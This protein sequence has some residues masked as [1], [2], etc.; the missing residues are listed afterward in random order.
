MSPSPTDAE[1]AARAA[2]GDDRAYADLVGRHKDGLYRLLRR[3]AGDPE[4]AHEAVQEAFIAAW[5]ALRRYDPARP[6]AAWLRTIAINKARD[7]ARRA[8]VR[9]LVFGA[10]RFEDSG[11]MEH[12][13]AE[14]PADDQVI[15]RQ[16]V[17]ALD[18]AIAA[19]P[20]A[21]KA[22]LILTALEGCS[23][24]EAAEILGVSAKA[25]ET[26]TYRARRLLMAT[27]GSMEAKAGR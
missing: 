3:Y 4:E 7:R 9:R 1:L 14:P 5:A 10:G 16:Q 27:L 23:Q 20:A 17:A 8:A 21:L 25:I 13:A 2:A 19:L 12:P 22:P 24:Q 6:F 11:A 18:R 26:R 15:V